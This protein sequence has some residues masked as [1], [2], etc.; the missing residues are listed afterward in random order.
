MFTKNKNKWAGLKIGRQGN[1]L[2]SIPELDQGDWDPG[3]VSWE[4]ACNDRMLLHADAP[5]SPERP[6]QAQGGDARALQSWK[7]MLPLANA[8]QVT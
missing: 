6:A 2:W 8:V 3:N 1:P 5:S 7:L 4:A